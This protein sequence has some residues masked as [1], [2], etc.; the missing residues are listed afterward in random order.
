M[1]KACT[2]AYLFTKH[3][4]AY[5]FNSE[6]FWA[7]SNGPGTIPTTRRVFPH[8]TLDQIHDT[9]TLMLHIRKAKKLVQG[10]RIT[11]GWAMIQTRA[12]LA[13]EGKLLTLG[14]MICSFKFPLLKKNFVFVAWQC[15]WMS[16][17]SIWLEATASQ[18][19]SQHLPVPLGL[20]T[21]R[22]ARV[23]GIHSRARRR[24]SSPRTPGPGHWGVAVSVSPSLLT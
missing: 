15:Q 7:F 14:Y 23:R 11:K 6:H 10:H 2:S 4:C 24:Q 9:S 20:T 8:R 16:G 19:L 12:S 18:S 22:I 3:F 21:F 17:S 5:Y 13:S 1:T